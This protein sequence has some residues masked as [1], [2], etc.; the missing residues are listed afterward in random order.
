MRRREFIA[1]VGAGMLSRS[2]LGQQTAEKLVR[3][4]MLGNGTASEHR[5]RDAFI[6]GL[7][8]LGL[9]EGKNFA[10]V[11][12]YSDGRVESYPSLAAEL[13]SEKA[14]IIVT[15]GPYAIRA[16]REAAGNLL[17][18]VFAITGDPVASG[19]AASLAH[20]GGNITGLSMNNLEISGKRLELLKELKPNISRVAVLDDAALGQD[21][22]EIMQIG[23]AARSLGIELQLLEVASSDEFDAAFAA[24]QSRQA[25]GLLVIPTPLFN[26]QRVRVRL[27][28]GALR[29]GLPSMYEEISYIRDGGLMS[30][31]PDFADMYRRA[32]GYVVRILKGAKAG[33]LPI[34]LPTKFALTINLKTAR[35]LG[36]TIPQSILVRADEVVE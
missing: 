32:A 12:R 27:A 8:D 9:V 21:R 16:V 15:A 10:I 3:I 1:A 24:A 6:A 2:A 5:L 35:A 13:I 34:E 28:E 29:H 33:D 20:P 25:E 36:I 4:G 17:P 11:D 23:S 14:D 18:I 19:F 31:G 26:L 22:Q 7:R 30:Y